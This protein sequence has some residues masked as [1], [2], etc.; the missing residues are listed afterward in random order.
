[1]GHIHLAVLPQTKKWRE[2]VDLLTSGAADTDVM[3]ASAIAAE[4]ELANASN[5]VVFIEALRLLFMIPFAARSKE[6][7][8]SLNEFGLDVPAEPHLVDLVLSVSQRLDLLA[9][10]PGNRTDFG[11]LSGRAVIA[12]LSTHIGDALPGLFEATPAD[13]QSAARRL[14]WQSGISD[15]ARSFFGR[16]LSDSLSTWLSRTLSTHVGEGR[17]FINS[18]DRAD[19]ERAL[20][21]YTREATRMIKEFAPGWYGK[22]LHMDGQ[23]TTET[24]TVFGAVA[25]KKITEELR[26]KRDADG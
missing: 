20:E 26:R 1:M 11:E 15:L 17:R 13:V 3:A 21:Q 10:A 23:I 16:L 8:R 7:G 24:A 12:A 9:A 4:R 5:D 14:S 19:F 2:V 25:F 22:R 6:F 18:S